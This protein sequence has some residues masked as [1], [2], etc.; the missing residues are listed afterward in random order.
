VEQYNLK[1]FVICELF[2]GKDSLFCYG[3]GYLMVRDS[4]ILGEGDICMFGKGFRL[5]LTENKRK[6]YSIN[7]ILFTQI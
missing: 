4:G 3:L 1:F 6:G 5:R 7:T 2:Q